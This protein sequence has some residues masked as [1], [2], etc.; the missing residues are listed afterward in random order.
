[1]KKINRDY[2]LVAFSEGCYLSPEYGEIADAIDR[3][4]MELDNLKLEENNGKYW[5]EH[6]VET[7]EK[8]NYPVY[9]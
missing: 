9:L 4:T 1:M 7:K 3:I 5:I 6:L 8:I 2:Y